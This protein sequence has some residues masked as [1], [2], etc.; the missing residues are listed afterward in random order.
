M[1]LSRTEGERLAFNHN[2]SPG[3][4]QIDSAPNPGNESQNVELDATKQAGLY[5][6]TVIS[7]YPAAHSCY[8]RLSGGSLG[9]T[10]SVASQG[11]NA[12]SGF[13]VNHSWLPQE[14]S[15]VLLWLDNPYSSIGTIIATLPPYYVTADKAKTHRHR[16]PGISPEP[17]VSIM[18]EAA[19][20]EPFKD[21]TNAN[22]V[23]AGGNKPLD[24]LPGEVS[25]LNE[26]GIG[27]YI[28]ALACGMR[29]SEGACI[30]FFALDDTVRLTSGLFQH[31]SAIGEQ[32]IYGDGGYQTLEF[33]GS[34]HLC[35]LLGKSDYDTT[36]LSSDTWDP[37][38]MSNTDLKVE[39]SFAAMISR[40]QMYLGHTAGLFSLFVSNGEPGQGLFS[41]NVDGSGRLLVSSAQDIIFE[42]TDRIPVPIKLADVWDPAGTRVDTDDPYEEKEPFDWKADED[43]RNHALWLNDGLAWYKRLL[44]Q[45][46]DEAAYDWSVP[47]ESDLAPPKNDYEK[48]DKL[49]ASEN[50]DTYQ[51]K[52]AAFVIGADGS[53][54]IRSEGGAEIVLAGGQVTINAPGDIRFQSGSNVVSLGRDIIMK[55]RDS[56]D[57]VASEKDLRLKAEKNLHAY[58]EQSILLQSN[59][60]KDF[61][62]WSSEPVGEDQQ[63]GGIALVAKKSRVFL[64]GQQVHLSAIQQLIQETLDTAKG[65]IIQS[66]KRLQ[67]TFKHLWFIGSRG[68][69]LTMGSSAG[70]YG[71]TVATIGSE[72]NVII[73]GQEIAAIFPWADLDSDPYGDFRNIGDGIVQTYLEQTKWLTPYQPEERE[74]IQFTHRTSEQMGTTSDIGPGDGSF[75]IYE[76]YWA[77]LATSGTGPSWLPSNTEEWTEEP[78]TD[79]YPWPGE[80]W[81]QGGGG[82]RRLESENNWDDY[83]KPKKRQER[84]NTGGT[85]SKGSVSQYRILK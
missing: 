9:V 51:D 14:G 16:P 66:T 58:S 56:V 11:N 70:L 53:I 28:G 35:E 76:S 49:L 30:D 31:Y 32:L 18:T 41:A 62:N 29:A 38:K 77:Y 46:M 55:G 61:N 1:P 5:F 6:G 84:S 44:Y 34:P 74:L 45:R 33:S 43:P 65:V 57:I 15:R 60:E 25:N 82:L 69:G 19:Y 12:L 59:A 83:T 85:I 48:L 8:V 4:R 17:G 52:R 21:R 37:S 64:Y 40:F 20:R 67:A 2:A 7:S 68:A 47:E 81:Y 50:Y 54:T 23:W 24:L 27:W 73:K 75:K 26:L 79:T 71:K 72:S 63:H 10:C 80:K 42:R 22:T 78:I 13:G 36:W 39:D 3:A